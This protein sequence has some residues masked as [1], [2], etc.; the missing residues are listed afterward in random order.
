MLT[1][2][3]GYRTMTY[4][5]T[6]TMFKVGKPPF[7]PVVRNMS[8][9]NQFQ[10]PITLYDVRLP[11]RVQDHFTVCLSVCLFVS[12]CRSVCPSICLSVS[13]VCVF[14]SVGMCFVLVV[15]WCDV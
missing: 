7:K 10:T 2:L 11:A 1:G 13:S 4:E 12:V 5:K 8:L 14:L 3:S 15:E 9:A 6:Q